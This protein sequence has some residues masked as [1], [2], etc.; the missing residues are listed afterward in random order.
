MGVV[1]VVNGDCDELGELTA[2]LVVGVVSVVDGERA[3]PLEHDPNPPLKKMT[4]IANPPHI[5]GGNVA[6]FAILWR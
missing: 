3:V 4:E 6:G 5:F 2:G 1:S